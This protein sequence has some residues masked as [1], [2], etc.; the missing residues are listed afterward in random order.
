MSL[1]SVFFLCI[2]CMYLQQKKVFGYVYV[3]C[4]L[5]IVQA[6]LFFYLDSAVM[7]GLAKIESNIGF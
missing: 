6:L 2:I 3:R 7:S 5:L 4:L 1:F